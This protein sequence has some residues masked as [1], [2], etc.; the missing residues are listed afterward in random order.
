MKRIVS[1]LL[2]VIMAAGIIASCGEKKDADAESGGQGAP[3]NEV[4]VK[5][6][7]TAAV[8]ER[9]PYD[10]SGRD[11]GGYEFV[12]WNYDNY[13]DNTWD[14]NTIPS[15]MESEELNG[16]ILNDAVY[17]RNKTV[18]EA[19][20]ISIK[21]QH[22]TAGELNDAI[23]KSIASGSN[24]V[25]AAFVR[26]YNFGGYITSSYL[27][28]LSGISS[29]NTDAEWYDTKANRAITISG[30]SFGLFTDAAYFDKLS[31]IVTF[32]NQ[33]LAADYQMG[34]LYE[35]VENNQW[36]MDRLLELGAPLSADLNNDGSFDMSDSYPLS[37]QN[38]AAY[39]LLHGADLRICETDDG[40]SVV[41]SLE[42]QTT[43]GVM[44]KIYE[45]MQDPTKFLNRQTF[46]A[47]LYDAINMFC[48]NRTMF[49]VRPLFSLF[50][51]RDME[52]DFGILPVPK[53]RENQ[54]SYGSA[55]NPY[56]ATIMVIPMSV[57]DPE[58]S[59]A[60]IDMMSWESH[61]SVIDPLYSNV[62]GNKLVRDEGAPEMLDIV[63]DSIVCDI[64]LVFNFGGVVDSLISNKSTD[65]V[66]MTAKI[67]NKVE[68]EIDKLNSFIA[69][70][71]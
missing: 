23:N 40:G 22:K 51:M 28:D 13:T 45:I 65:V 31:T 63:F 12:I 7:E 62:L 27:L 29:F 26:L 37:C 54:Q 9:V 33:K 20:N 49:L 16:E 48:E 47:T 24:D 19:L 4:D 55:V 64:G 67:K 59:G 6:E 18:E 3:V 5:T 11:F 52:A 36:T 34:N 53:M 15:D 69:G 61:Y 56:A 41:F 39:Y 44:Q 2:S 66:S 10:T 35:T 30:R 32:F 50:Q 21:V 43:V 46:G 60:V 38:D 1:L 68:K 17:N 14:R 25:D 70:M 42:D 8:T 57:S 58:R 71:E